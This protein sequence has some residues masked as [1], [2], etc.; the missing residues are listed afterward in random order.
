MRPQTIDMKCV[1]QLAGPRLSIDLGFH[2]SSYSDIK[3]QYPR[4]SRS[5]ND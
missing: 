2:L 4:T 3:R 5:E 1:T